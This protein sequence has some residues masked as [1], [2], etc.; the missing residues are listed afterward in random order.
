MPITLLDIILLAVMLISGLLAMIRGFM[1]EILSIAAWGVAAL[2]TLYAYSPRC[3]RLAK[4][5]F[6]SDMVAA[7]VTAGG[8]FLGTLLIV[9]IIT[10]RISD[11]VLDSRVGALDRTLGFLFGLGRGLIIVVVAFLFFAWLVPDRSQPEWV[12]SAKSK[13]VLQNTG[14][15]LMSMLPDDP[16]STILK[17]LKKPKPDDQDTPDTRSRPA[18]GTAVDATQGK[19]N[20]ITMH[21]IPQDL[22]TQ[23]PAT[24]ADAE[25]DPDA[26]RLR[27]ECGVFG[28]FGHP[29]AAA[30]TALGLHALQH[31]GQEAAG[32]VSFDG[33]R[34]PFRAP[35]R[36][37]RR[38]LCAPRSDR[39]PAR[40]VRHRPCALFDHR[41][42]HPAQRAAAVRRTRRRR[43]RHRPQRQ[44]DQWHHA[45][46]RSWCTKAP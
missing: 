40:H 26:D 1:R 45:A 25:F 22:P 21:T 43:L 24:S 10:A 15:W 39:P 4:Q 9:S 27:E 3:C 32:I 7:G 20:A 5:Y 28:I 42:N 19:R 14:Q 37:G 2:V 13:V 18:F 12:R 33:K 34:F 41:R 16:E 44:S 29:D 31:R 30:I 46:P 36:P 6:N 35:P 8:V 23:L 17:R 11:M 38:C